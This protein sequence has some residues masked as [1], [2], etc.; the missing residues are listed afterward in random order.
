MIALAV[1]GAV[2]LGGDTELGPGESVLA[3][4]RRGWSATA[5]SAPSC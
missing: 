1:D 3:D 4:E 5:R 2:Q